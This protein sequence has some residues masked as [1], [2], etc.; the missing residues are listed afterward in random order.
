MSNAEL[1]SQEV[2]VT[3]TSG[4][5]TATGAA[6]GTTTIAEGV[7]ATIAGLAAR[8]VPGVHEMTGSGLSQAFGSLSGFFTGGQ[9]HGDKGVA[10]EVGEVECIVDVNIV[11]EYG[12]NVPQVGEAIRRDVTEQLKTL[13]GLEAKQVNVNIADIVL[14]SSES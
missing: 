2:F 13:T 5:S 7:V 3:R 9:D 6:T 8:R 4:S 12:A 14:P 1:A 10:V 11:I